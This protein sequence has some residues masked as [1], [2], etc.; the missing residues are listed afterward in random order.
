MFI[1][2]EGTKKVAAEALLDV[3]K[4]CLHAVYQVPQ[5]DARIKI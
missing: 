3:A 1:D 4:H 2:D 5:I